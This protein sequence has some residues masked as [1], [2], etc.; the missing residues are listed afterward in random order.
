VLLQAGLA[1][2]FV[3]CPDGH[4]HEFLT[5]DGYHIRLCG[6]LELPVAAL[7][8]VELP[9]VCLQPLD[10]IANFHIAHQYTIHSL[11]A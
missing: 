9:A 2:N 3:Q 6:V 7:C 1:P 10:D 11:A 5:S 8:P 4:I